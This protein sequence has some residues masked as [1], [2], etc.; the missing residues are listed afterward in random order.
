MN[1]STPNWTPSTPLSVAEERPG[2][3]SEFVRIEII[4]DIAALESDWLAFQ[5]RAA[6]TVFQTYQWCKLWQEA[7]GVARGVEPVI[8][9]GRDPSGRLLFLLP[10]SRR[11]S[12][13]INVLEWLGGQ[14]M[15][16]GF[17]LYDRGFLRHAG[18]WFAAEG[19]S[20]LDRVG[21]IDALSL[22][23][24]PSPWRSA[25][26]PLSS[27]FSL[28]GPNR[29]Y[30]MELGSDYETLY[31][32]KRSPETRRGNR[33][34]DQRLEK[35]GKVTFGLP[36]D[37]AHAHRLIDEMF[38]QQRERLAEGG[39][40]GVF[41]A[42]ERRFIHRLID[43]PDG[44]PPLLY[45]YHLSIDGKLEAMSLVARHGGGFWA[46][47]S[48]LG[49]PKYRKLSP[50]DYTLRR[51]IAA[52]ADQQL[53]FFDLAAGNFAYKQ[54]W[55]DEEVRLHYAIRGLTARGYAFAAIRTA[56]IVSK[57]TIKQ[58][59]ALWAAAGWI[60]RSLAGRPRN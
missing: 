14:Q 5:D 38:D 1:Q 34:R 36:S 8:V 6:G 17:G 32:A 27:W 7:A 19:W 20:I 42:D 29:S 49:S 51:A 31:A 46:L 28:E 52:G 37:R 3:A 18:E 24:M 59:P 57:R 41:T 43:M 13:G 55:A 58:T 23:E 40:H 53:S 45:P 2:R 39:I 50:G 48:S 9:T 22:A 11:R 10:F 35:E 15:T 56:Y 33:K 4:R 54:V 44:L 12:T 21:G 16:Y 30:V 47:I 25:R 60:K 26:H